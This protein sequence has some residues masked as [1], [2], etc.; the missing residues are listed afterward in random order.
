MKHERWLHIQELFSDAIDLNEQERAAFLSRACGE[1]ATLRREV[2]SLISSSEKAGEFIEAAIVSAMETVTEDLQ[3]ATGNRIGPYRIERELGRG[4]MGNVFLAV[5]DDDE[6]RKQVAIKVVRDGLHS[7]E[8]LR[9]FRSERQILAN[10]DHPNIARLLDGGTTE[11]G[12]PYVVMEYVDGEPI[13]TYCDRRRLS[14]GE[15]LNL[16]RTICAAVHNAH[17][18]LIVHRDLKPSNILVTT[19]GTLKL[20]DFGIAKLL[21]PDLSEDTETL[22]RTDVRLMT[23]EYASP[24]QVRG[25]PITTASDVYTLGV[26]LYELL[27]GQRPYHF[28][29]HTAGEMERVVCEQEPQKPST[30]VTRG[31]EAACETDNGAEKSAGALSR[32]RASTTEKLR[33]QLRG[34]L[35]NV[36]LKAMRKDTT[37]RYVSVEQLSE[38]IRRHL[39][40]LPVLAR[41]DSLG[42]RT[43]K[44]IGRHRLGVVAST[45]VVLLVA[46]MTAFYT[47]RLA[48][49]RDRAQIEAAK[50]EKVSEFL[51]GLFEVSDPSRSRGQTVTARELLDRGAERIEKELAGQPDVQARMMD[52]MGNV[53]LG[54]GLYNEAAALLERALEIRLRLHGE[55][56]AEVA[57]TLNALSVVNR[58]SGDYPKARSLAARGLE[59]QRRLHGQE[60][61]AVAHSMA[62]LAEVLR[63]QGDLYE[64]EAIYRQALAMR[65]RLLGAE[66]ADVADTKNN[67][68]L[69]IHA[70]GDY[71]GAAIMHREA[72]DLRRRV[73]GEM[74]PDVANSYDNLALVLTALG[75]LDEAERLGREA[76]RLN[77]ALLGESEPRTVR[78][79]ARL[80]RT[81]FARG[82]L[83]GGEQL[84]RQA[85]AAFREQL[86]DHHPYVAQSLNDLAEMRHAAGDRAD[87]ATLYQQALTLRRQLLVPT[88]P[89]LAESLAGFG[90]LLMDENRNEEAEP[91]LREAL[92]IRKA[93]MIPRHS[94]TGEV[95]SLLG[96]CLTKLGRHSEAEPLVL[97]GFETLRDGCGPRD[98]RTQAALRRIISLYAAW[99][100]PESEAQY[101]AL[102]ASA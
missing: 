89:S 87:A 56:H 17:Q 64:A 39:E 49:E 40:G 67:L 102:L 63:V 18:N 62:D 12:L 94:T 60:H 47:L 66:H 1:D 23:P 97:E 57:Q 24:E 4:G 61:L 55:V 78:V 37:R 100:K 45:V 74:H 2:E 41:S 80:A 77:Q 19:A 51:A 93:V 52:L 101:K 81:L 36:V 70:R 32:K 28:K 10:L 21:N 9:R 44:F 69:T 65:V 73:S 8:L 5:R 76:L 85:L 35:D 16:F 82:D 83:S 88:S 22:T 7:R 3:P 84:A 29:G 71:A 34:D 50:A 86:G 72:L 43:Q 15:R 13:D 54:L 42:Y 59:I 53:H 6:Y 96:A 58:L 27:T 99:G 11:T 75:E 26:V 48:N 79:R 33:R 98:P 31:K 25:L 92:S 95:M 20:L 38:D 68:A 90:S 30:V 91:L 46:A 14:I